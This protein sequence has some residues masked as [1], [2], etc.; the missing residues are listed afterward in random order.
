ML[1]DMPPGAYCFIDANILYYHLVETPPFSDE[2]SDFL[3][4]IE[5][6]ELI[7]VTSS[8]TVGEVIHKVMM[9]EVALLKNEERA[10]LL[11]KLKRH[12]EW[13]D[14]LS[15]HQSVIST[16]RVLNLHV[17]PVTLDLLELAT[18]LSV[19]HRLLTNDALT[20]AVMKKLGVTHLATN[21]DDFDNIA[22]L[23]VWKPR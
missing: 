20:V 17:E 13:L 22:G 9:K 8:N 4:R 2:C 3:E 23:T 10:G 11:S 21:D 15:Q 16:L 7:G 19:K 6:A 1:K 14:A 18:G 5:K 12:P